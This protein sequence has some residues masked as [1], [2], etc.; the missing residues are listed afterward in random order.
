MNTRSNA[1]AQRSSKSKPTTPHR[2]RRPVQYRLPQEW[3]GANSQEAPPQVRRI[4]IQHPQ[5]ETRGA[6]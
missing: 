3:I 5:A 6:Q 1:K 2:R 4:I